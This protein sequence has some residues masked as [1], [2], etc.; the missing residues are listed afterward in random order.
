MKPEHIFLAVVT[1]GAIIY[2]AKFDKFKPDH[3]EFGAD[4]TSYSYDGDPISP[5]D[6]YMDDYDL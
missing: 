1:L 3:S 6:V 2:Y 4:Y 5:E